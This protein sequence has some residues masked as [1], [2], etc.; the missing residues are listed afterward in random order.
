MLTI[1]ISEISSAFDW[2]SMFSVVGIIFGII[3]VFPT[4]VDV[5]AG[6]G[7]NSILLIIIIAL[8][9]T[10]D[11]LPGD[12]FSMINIS[13]DGKSFVS[14]DELKDVD[15]VYYDG[16]A[17]FDEVKDMYFY[18]GKYYFKDPV[19]GMH[20]PG[21]LTDCIHIPSW[22]F[23]P[24]GIIIWPCLVLGIMLIWAVSIVE[25]VKDIVKS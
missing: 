16:E 15:D 19:F 14:W 10:S 25:L 6:I 20:A 17:S 9:G 2:H 13:E 24:T 18:D 8:V 23:H 1:N 4:L 7:I 3:C 22:L 21:S 5:R 12:A 11:P